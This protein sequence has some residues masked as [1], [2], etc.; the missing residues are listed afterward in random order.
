[1]PDPEKPADPASTTASTAAAATDPAAQAA[2]AAAATSTVPADPAT[3]AAPARVIPEKY[4]LTIPP[5]AAD[6]LDPADLTQIA[7]Q[8]KVAGLTNEE[9]QIAVQRRADERSEQSAAFLAQ[10]QA[11]PEYGGDHLADTQRRLNL[12]LDT[13]RPAGSPRGD[14]FRALL[15]KTGYGNHPE[16]V[17]FLSDLAS[18]I[19]EDRPGGGG[20]GFEG[21]REYKTRED[22]YKHTAPTT[23]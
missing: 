2:S 6:W 22:L 11:D 23:S 7:A 19:A 10:V 14:A 12:V 8:A 20:G 15:T 3:T 9:A 16:V 17:T 18:T 21:T 1:M 5:E 13:I 4:S